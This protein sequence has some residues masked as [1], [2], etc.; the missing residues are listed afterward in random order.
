M[1]RMEQFM[2][3]RFSPP[4]HLRRRYEILWHIRCFFTVILPEMLCTVL[5]GAILI[6]LPVL[7]AFFS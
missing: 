5:F 6:L 2:I 7:A 4:P 1:E 3:E